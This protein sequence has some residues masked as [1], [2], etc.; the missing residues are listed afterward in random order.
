MN[1]YSD[2]LCYWNQ[3]GFSKYFSCKEWKNKPDKYDDSGAKIH[4]VNRE[5]GIPY[6]EMIPTIKNETTRFD[7]AHRLKSDAFDTIKNEVNRLLDTGYKA[8]K[9]KI[10]YKPKS[11]ICSC[12]T[13]K[14]RYIVL[15]ILDRN[16]KIGECIS[17]DMAVLLKQPGSYKYAVMRRE[18]FD[19][20]CDKIF[21]EDYNLDCED[22]REMHIGEVEIHEKFGVTKCPVPFEL[23]L[24]DEMGN[25]VEWVLVIDKKDADSAQ[26]T[27]R[28]HCDCP[29]KDDW[30]TGSWEND[31]DI[32][33]FCTDD[34][35]KIDGCCTNNQMG[36]LQLKFTKRCDFFEWLCDNQC[37]I[38]GDPRFQNLSTYLCRVLVLQ[39]A[40]Y[41]YD[42]IFLNVNH[43]SGW[44]T[45]KHEEYDNQQKKLEK[46]LHKGINGKPS[47]YQNLINEINNLDVCKLCKPEKGYKIEHAEVVTENKGS[48]WGL[49]V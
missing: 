49:G 10:G 2:W 3:V 41:I 29:H 22:E 46:I 36:G 18:Q 16:A 37:D 31:F 20:D 47:E 27:L 34:L 6:W 13:C 35:C 9:H 4:I 21:D 19:C 25:C 17:L 7:I 12:D 45:Q 30:E 43:F 26:T 11:G 44:T 28:E 8:T 15:C 5:L 39:T 48:F 40:I 33:V 38:F 14:G 1:N 42:F 32:Q 24:T 23:C